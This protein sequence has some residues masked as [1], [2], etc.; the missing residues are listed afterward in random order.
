VINVCYTVDAPFVGGAELYVSRI[1]TRLDRGRFRPT[2]VMRQS[3]DPDSGLEEWG[4]ELQAAGVPVVALPM[5]LPKKP[6]QMYSVLRVISGTNPHVVHVN[7]PGP[8]DGQMGL[9]V[10]LSR[11]AGATGVVVTEHLPMV[12]S[13]WKRRLLKRFSYRWVDRVATVCHANVPYLTERQFVR[14]GKVA[15]IHNAL[16]SGYGRGVGSV[17]TEIR[18]QYRFPVDRTIVAFVGNL[19][20]H[21]GLHRIVN[22]LI[23]MRGLPWHLAVIGDGPERARNEQLLESNGL[24]DRATFT[25]KVSS[26]EVERILAVVDVLVLPSTTEGMPYVILEAMA[27]SVPVVAT[28]V[29]GIPEMVV[30]GETGLLVKTDDNPGLARA[31]ESMLE[32]PAERRR[33]GLAARSRFERL[34]TLD[35][36]LAL[37]ERLYT[38][39]AGLGPARPR[40]PGSA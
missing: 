30:D 15:V 28:R 26:D 7:M 17:K 20:E 38:E 2:V 6:F 33:M 19:L 13:T 11:M 18:E 40:N 27:S 9:L 1:A 32:N 8:Q 5:D 10:P 35:G 36:Q 14:P 25:G 39:V 4:T 37:I 31:L 34:F 16:D 12:E 29:Y 3:A 21:K 24:A 23:E 22:A